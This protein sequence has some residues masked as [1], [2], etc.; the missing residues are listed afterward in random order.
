MDLFIY[1]ISMKHFHLLS[2]TFIYFHLTSFIFI[3]FI[4]FYL[5]SS[6]FIYFQ[7]LSSIYIIPSS[8]LSYDF[9]NLKIFFFISRLCIDL[10]ID[11]IT[12]ELF[13]SVCLVRLSVTRLATIIYK[14]T[15]YGQ[16]GS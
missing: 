9:I 3:Y 4:Y 6:T 13:I 7:L 5:L 8:I 14:V 10:L 12:N 16:K 15:R 1:T 2:S 11:V